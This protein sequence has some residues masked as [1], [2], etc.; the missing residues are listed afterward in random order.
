MVRTREPRSARSEREHGDF[1]IQTL[2]LGAGVPWLTAA[3][4]THRGNR[5]EHNEDRVLLEPTRGHGGVILAVCDGM[6]G[7][8]GG[9]VAAEIATS[10]LEALAKVARRED[11]AMALEGG[12]RAADAAIRLRGAQE[13]GRGAMG[14]TAVAAWV[15]RGMVR[16]AHAGDS[17]MLHLRGEEVLAQTKDHTV[18]QALVDA[19]AASVAE[20]RTHPLKA[21][22]TSALGGGVPEGKVRVD[23]A[24]LDGR[25]GD[26]LLLFSDGLCDALDDTRIAELA[27]RGEPAEVVAALMDAALET[28]ARDN[29]SVVAARLGPGFARSGA[30]R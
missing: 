18:V 2:T 6:G 28:E 3:G 1:R 14:T 17:R 5:R 16:V 25:P 12:L 22:L 9:D 30:R 29:V 20:A 21:Q 10:G 24:A 8:G 11:F 26:T 23:L 27:S 4:A 7:H 19:G 15:R 13:I